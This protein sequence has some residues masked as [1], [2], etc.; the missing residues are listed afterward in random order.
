MRPFAARSTLCVNLARGCLA[1]G[2]VAL[3]GGLCLL[4]GGTERILAAGYGDALAHAEHDWTPAPATTQPKLWLSNTANSQSHAIRKPVVIGDRISIG[5]AGE[6]QAFKVLSV[7]HV[8]A[9]AGGLA[10][11]RIQIVTAQP[12]APVAGETVRFI[13]A[14]DAAPATPKPEKLL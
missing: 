1:L 11:V 13:F 3:V 6:L 14:V 9:D 4:T 12:D 2:A 7:E 5:Q 10:G 8:D